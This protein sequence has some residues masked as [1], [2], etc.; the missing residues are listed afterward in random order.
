M[1]RGSLLLE[2]E[3]GEGKRVLPAPDAPAVFY[4]PSH[5]FARR[6]MGGRIVSA[7]GNDYLSGKSLAALKDLLLGLQLPVPGRRGDPGDWRKR[8]LYPFP[9]DF[10]HYDALERRGKIKIE[11]DS[12]RGGGGLAHRMLR[13]DPNGARLNE[14][15]EGFRVLFEDSDSPLGVLARALHALDEALEQSRVPWEDKT[16]SA[17]Q[18]IPSPWIEQLRDGAWRIVT[19]DDIP[20]S[21]RIDA[22]MVWVPYCI[23]RHQQSLAMS[24]LGGTDAKLVAST[25]DCL[26]KNSPLRDRA[27]HDFNSSWNAIRT[28]LLA[29][30][31]QIGDDELANGPPAWMDSPRTFFAATAYA[32]GACNAPTGVRWFALTPVLIEA[33]VLAKVDRSMPFGRFCYEILYEN[34][35]MVIDQAAAQAEGIIDI[36]QSTFDANGESL[37]EVMADLGLLER[38]SDTTRMV[39]VGR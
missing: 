10:V 8:H 32:I 12:Y 6:I 14:T 34:L 3:E 18:V 15:R 2:L 36:D 1:I 19:R 26:P 4:R 9:A 37:S 17:A 29:R 13:S 23:L 30:A 22:L 7:V 27:R 20:G 39:G 31:R 33:V 24:R 25:F 38:Y 21:R 35:G 28:A 5:D 16:E 11:G